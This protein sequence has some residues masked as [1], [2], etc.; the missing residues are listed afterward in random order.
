MTET[1]G[2]LTDNLAT[3]ISHQRDI[4][5]KVETEGEAIAGPIMDI[6]GSIQ[7]QDII[8]Q[9]LEQLDRMAEMVDE[10]IGSIGVMLA[11]RRVEPGEETLSQKLD[12]MFSTY[13]MAGQREAHMAAHGQVESKDSGSLIE[14]F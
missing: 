3:I 10:H 7:F 6:M 13:V 14:M 9:Q 12:N 11:S 1:L 2:A 4:L 5:Q 8:R